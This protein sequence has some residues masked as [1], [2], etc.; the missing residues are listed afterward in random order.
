P[1]VPPAGGWT[2]MPPGKSGLGNPGNRHA[3]IKGILHGPTTGALLF[4]TIQHDVDKGLAS[5]CIDVVEN[6]SGD[7]DQEGFK[8]TFIPRL[9]D[10]AD[11]RSRCAG[12]LLDQVIRFGNQLHVGV[13]DAVVNHLDEVAG[14]V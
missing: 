11:L 3:K 10:L 1:G 2:R 12:A 14:T 5:L 9:E 8:I 7:F 13:L 4:S 6:L